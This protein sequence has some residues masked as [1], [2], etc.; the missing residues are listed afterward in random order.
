[1]MAYAKVRKPLHCD[2]SLIFPLI[3]P[4][5]NCGNTGIIRP[6]PVTSSNSVMKIKLIAALREEAIL[7]IED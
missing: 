7:E 4:E 3:R 6:K 1:M 2:A 5:I